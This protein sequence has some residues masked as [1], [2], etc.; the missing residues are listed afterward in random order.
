M[1]AGENPIPKH[2]VQNGH[3]VASTNGTHHYDDKSWGSRLLP[4]VA[5]QLAVEDP[6]KIYASVA[7]TS[8]I[9]DGFRDVT[10]L[11]LTNAVNFMAWWLEEH[12]GRSDTF[13]TIAYMGI[14]DIRYN[15][16]FLAAVKCGYKLLIPSLRNSVMMNTSLFKT[17]GCTKIFYSEEVESRIRELEAGSP[18]LESHLMFP[19]DHMMKEQWRLYPYNKDFKAVEK[20]PILVCHTSGSTVVLGPPERP[21]TGDMVCEIMRHFPLRAVSC[22]PSILEQI[23]QE[24][25]GL[26][27]AGNLDFVIYTGGPLSPAAGDTLSKV[28]DVCQLYGQSETGVIA[29]LVP[30]REDWAFFEFQPAYGHTMELVG[31]E[32]YEMIIERDMSLAW[33][34]GICHTF[35]EM[36]D[37]WRFHGRTDDIMVLGNGEK[38][39]PSPMEA[40][41]QGHPLVGGA[42]IAGQGRFQSCLI[43]EPKSNAALKGDE[44]IDEIWGFVEQANRSGPGHAKIVRSLVAVVEPNTHF[45]RAGKGTVIRGQ[46]TKACAGV[47]DKLYAEASSKRKADA[48]L[49]PQPFNAADVLP[50]VRNIISTLFPDLK[51]RDTDDFFNSGLDSLQTIELVSALRAGL[52]EHRNASEQ[53]WLAVKTI[54]TRPSIIALSE[55]LSYHLSNDGNTE[56]SNGNSQGSRISDMKR[57]VQRYTSD[58]PDLLPVSR[59]RESKLHVVLT[60]STGSL[61]THILEALMNDRK[62]RQITCMNRSADARQRHVE[63]FERRGLGRKYHLGDS[64]VLFDARGIIGDRDLGSNVTFVKADFGHPTFGLPQTAFTELADDV[65]VIIHNAWKVDFNHSLASFEETHIRGVR[66]FIEWSIKSKKHSA[67]FFVSSISSV[68][69]WPAGSTVPE[70]PHEDYGVASQLGYGESKHVSERILSNASERSG[71]PTSILRVGQIAGPLK[72]NGGDWN[73]TEWL[74]CL[75]KLSLSMRL[76]PQTLPPIDWIPVDELAAIILEIVHGRARSNELAIFNLVNPHPTTWEPLVAPVMKRAGPHSRLVPTQQWVDALRQ[77]DA[78]DVEET[79]AKPALKI[80]DFFDGI[81]KADEKAALRYRTENGVAASRRMK[82]LSAVRPEWMERWL[83]QWAF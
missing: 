79:K 27:M 82:D 69:N 48:P 47:I 10:I 76:F 64:D 19:L 71:V 34:R 66:H 83:D 31:D 51:I 75:V 44:L 72:R 46:T 74:P 35:P 40:I 42:L 55:T 30:R 11:E 36:E 67:I 70:T 4:M 13:E 73:K 7:K 3:A 58:L 17:T 53:A 32:E 2:P 60:G 41:V 23:V 57:I 52:Q 54:Y 61:G 29:A 43:I 81:A 22:A 1:A 8:N 20:D 50:F 5:D 38:F 16:V 39:N 9:A 21:A 15:V 37:L 65:D 49:L 78:S 12:F 68:G 33:M 77:S 18:S 14:S 6:H 80:L 45:K 25:G 59:P 24:D 62:V 63:N 28:T 26:R 56:Q